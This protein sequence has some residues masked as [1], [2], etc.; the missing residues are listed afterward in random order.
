MGVPDQGWAFGRVP[1]LGR[2]FSPSLTSST[3]ANT[4]CDG[5]HTPT[6]SA[7]ALAKGYPSPWLGTFRCFGFG[8]LGRFQGLNGPWTYSDA[9]RPANRV[10]VTP[11]QKFGHSVHVSNL[12]IACS[13]YGLGRNCAVRSRRRCSIGASPWRRSETAQPAVDAGYRLG[14]SDGNRSCCCAGRAWHG[15][16]PRNHRHRKR[17]RGFGRGPPC[18]FSCVVSVSRRRSGTEHPAPSGSWVGD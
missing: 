11:V 12:K 16:I 17:R 18:D 15:G 3:F 5:G 7:V 2:S 13:G 1:S 8:A 14:R 6:V 10:S 4:W 9:C